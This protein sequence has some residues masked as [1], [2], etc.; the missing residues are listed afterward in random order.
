MKMRNFL[1]IVLLA[2]FAWSCSGA[3]T[4]PTYASAGNQAVKT[5]ASN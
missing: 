4:C 2:A 3:K 5:S 1:A